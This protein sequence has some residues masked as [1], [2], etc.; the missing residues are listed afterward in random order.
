MYFT[1]T[2]MYFISKTNEYTFTIPFTSIIQ[3]YIKQ[4][5]IFNEP[6]ITFS[7]NNFVEVF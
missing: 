1:E 7:T 4:L 2:H 6:C 3:F 5:D